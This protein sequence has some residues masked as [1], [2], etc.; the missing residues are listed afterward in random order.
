MKRSRRAFLRAAVAAGVAG[1]AGCHNEGAGTPTGRGATGSPGATTPTASEPS[2]GSTEQPDGGTPTPPP[3]RAAWPTFQFDLPNTGVAPLRG[4][5]DGQPQE[6]WRVGFDEP[7]TVQPVFDETG[8]FVPTRDAVYGLDREGGARRWRF[9]AGQ[10][11]PSTP[12]VSGEYV[13]VVTGNGA[14]KIHARE[15]WTAWEFNFTEQFEN[16]LVVAGKSPPTVVDDRVYAHLVM[17]KTSGS[18]SA[19][20]RVVALD[21]FDGGQVWRFDTSR[22]V[23]TSGGPYA[24]APAI[25]GDRLYFTTAHGQRSAALYALGVGG[26]GKAW[27]TGYDGHGRSSPTVAGDTV[28]VADQFAHGYAVA[29]GSRRFR[30][31]ADPPPSARGLA[32]TEDRVFVSSPTFGG[33]PGTLFGLDR[34]GRVRWQFAGDGDMYVPTATA[35]TV[36]VG[37]GGG[38]L[39][40]LSTSDGSPRWE[41]SLGDGSAVVSAPAIATRGLYVTATVGSGGAATYALA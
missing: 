11:A 1:T 2:G 6:E 19:V 26:G 41:F 29:D 36:F 27:S 14:F 12:A 35:D 15:G 10:A 16:L 32:V 39:Y 24:P 22:G 20:S 34:G 13:Y 25:D 9:D 18:P 7:A 30:R 28:Y 5:L 38:T 4:R 37:D 8:L 3:G 31:R 33:E 23:N 21:D 40:A 17:Q